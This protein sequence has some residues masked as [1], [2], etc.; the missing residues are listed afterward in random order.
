M[1]SDRPTSIRLP[2]SIDDIL[3]ELSEELNATK[4]EIIRV[5]LETVI[6]NKAMFAAA[7]S[8]IKSKKTKPENGVT[9][10]QLLTAIR[11]DKL[12]NDALKA[13]LNRAAK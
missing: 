13:A 4:S 10:R 6:S 5:C 9:N 3:Q 12:L 11:N 2:S 8:K 1:Q 7:K